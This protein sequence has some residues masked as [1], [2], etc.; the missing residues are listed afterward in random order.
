M[1]VLTRHAIEQ[2]ESRGITSQTEVL[3]AVRKVEGRL[4]LAERNIKVVVRRTVFTFLP[5]G[6]NGDTI[7]ACVTGEGI[8]KTVMLERSK[9]LERQQANGVIV[10]Q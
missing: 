3:Q 10:L 6:S 2:I 9:Q 7:I 5:D 1:A 8:I 4:P